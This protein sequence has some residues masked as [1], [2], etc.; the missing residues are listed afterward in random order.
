[1]IS[2]VEKYCQSGNTS[3]IIHNTVRFICPPVS[4]LWSNNE[5]KYIFLIKLTVVKLTAVIDSI[6]M[7][8]SI[9]VTIGFLDILFCA[10]KHRIPISV[11]G[12][13]LYPGLEKPGFAILRTAKEN[14]IL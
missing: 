9:Q 13:S 8:F 2:M 5:G 14:G 4:S 10:C 6:Y 7:N 12:I 1:M 3:C 11:T